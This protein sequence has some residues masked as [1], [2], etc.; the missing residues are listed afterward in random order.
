MEYRAVV[1]TLFGI[2]HEI[3]NAFGRALFVQAQFDIAHIGFDDDF[4]FGLRGECAG[5]EYTGQQVS[6]CMVHHNHSFK[7]KSSLHIGSF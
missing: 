4:G 2:S 6:G 7:Q 1:K 3:G 5:G